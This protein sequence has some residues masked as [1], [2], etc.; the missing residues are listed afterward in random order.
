MG[1]G[2]IIIFCSHTIFSLITIICTNIVPIEGDALLAF[3]SSLA[4]GGHRKQ[5]ITR[6]IVAYARISDRVSYRMFIF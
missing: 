2:K 4:H 5:H 6:K 1:I 3:G